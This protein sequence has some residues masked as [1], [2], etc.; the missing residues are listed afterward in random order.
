M[1]LSHLTKSKYPS[2]RCYR[3]S[4]LQENHYTEFSLEE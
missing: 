4:D 2:F 3:K 1:K